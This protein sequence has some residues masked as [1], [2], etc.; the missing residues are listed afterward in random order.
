MNVKILL[1]LIISLSHIRVENVTLAAHLW[2][3]VEL[4]KTSFFAVLSSKFSCAV[5]KNLILLQTWFGNFQ[6]ISVQQLQIINRK[7][8]TI[9]FCLRFYVRQSEICVYFSCSVMGI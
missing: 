6:S 1:K 8:F 5:A 4:S 2:G 7:Q 9:K 3:Q